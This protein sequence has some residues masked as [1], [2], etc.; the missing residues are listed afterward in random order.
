MRNPVRVRKLK[1][2]GT[3]R[4]E[5]S[6]DLV[7]V[8]PDGW[9]VVY[10]DAARHESFKDGRPVTQST[11]EARDGTWTAPHLFYVLS[12]REPLAVAFAFDALGGLIAM[13]ADAALPATA[14]GRVMSFVDLELDLV[15]GTDYSFSARDF[16]TFER[17]AATMSYDEA[18]RTA[19]HE[20]LALAKRLVLE[21]AYP[22][23]GSMEQLLGMVLAS[24]GPL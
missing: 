1:Y 11:A 16:E 21:R 18:A 22:F 2:D 15:I 7:E 19:A 23:D 13:H 24:E 8:R 5:F 10:H 20:G 9:L 14:S 3:V 4:R 12:E 6:G 17:N